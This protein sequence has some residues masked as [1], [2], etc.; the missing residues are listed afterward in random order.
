VAPTDPP[1]PLP[2]RSRVCS[3]VAMAATSTVDP[4]Q[5]IPHYL[6]SGLARTVI[7]TVDDALKRRGNDAALTF[8]RA[9][10]Y[11]REGGSRGG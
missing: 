6:R 2:L 11:G 9:V 5:L 3:S 10:A 8:W 4:K 7:Q 1:P